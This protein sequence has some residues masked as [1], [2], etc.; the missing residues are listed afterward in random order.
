MP[1]VTESYIQA[2]AEVLSGAADTL[3]YWP[4]VEGFGVLPTAAFVTVY[5]PNGGEVVA[6]TEVTPES[7]GRLALS[8]TWDTSSSPIDVEYFAVWEFTTPDGLSH[9]DRQSFDVVKSKLPILLKA[10]HLLA[11]YPNLRK[12][13]E[14][15]QNALATP[16]HFARMGW[17]DLLERV[18]ATGKR[19]SL[20]MERERLIAPARELALSH[21]SGALVKSAGD[22]WDS[23]AKA[24]LEHFSA[25]F[26]G[27]GELAYDVDED[28]T[29]GEDEKRNV[30]IRDWSV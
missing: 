6:R 15:L 29:T 19:P 4:A 10:A 12:H 13:L 5:N 27:L 17:E 7:T 30:V 25:L 21:A 16:E 8:R 24:H 1:E 28:N 14:S 18:R 9:A 26:G 22:V 20:I 11:R 3:A 2:R 23:R